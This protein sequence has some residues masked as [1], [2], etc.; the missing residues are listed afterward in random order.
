MGEIVYKFLPHEHA[1]QA[2][3]K[4]RLK[5][6]TLDRVNDVFDSMPRIGPSDGD[7]QYLQARFSEDFIQHHR[8]KSGILC[9]SKNCGNPLLW[10]HYAAYGTGVALGFDSD[11]LRH[12]IKFDVDYSKDRPLL[13]IPASAAD[14]TVPFEETIKLIKTVF[15]VKAEDWKYESEVRCVIELDD[16]KP[17]DRMYFAQFHDMD[18]AEVVLGYH[19]PVS[20]DYMRR[21]LRA[22]CKNLSVMLSTT[23]VDPYRYEVIKRRVGTLTLERRSWQGVPPRPAGA[24]SQARDETESD[25]K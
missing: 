13:R 1:I 6:T 21:T 2:I 11:R 22:Y 14:E 4:K 5:V 17:Q 3:E 16:C 9:F 19:C 18:L 20:L 10:G 25:A 7:P 24:A 12:R 8:K 23:D 15:G